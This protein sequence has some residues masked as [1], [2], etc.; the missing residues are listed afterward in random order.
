MRVTSREVVR[1]VHGGL[2]TRVTKA[3]KGTPT[4][5]AILSV[6]QAGRINPKMDAFSQTRNEGL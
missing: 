2:S 5:E 1:F 6:L 4:S 3:L